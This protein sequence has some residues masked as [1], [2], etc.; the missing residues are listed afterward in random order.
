TYAAPG[1]AL[2]PSPRLDD[3]VPPVRRGHVDSRVLRDV[4]PAAR[5]QAARGRSRR[6]RAVST[7]PVRGAAAPVREGAALPLRVHELP[8]TAREGGVGEAEADRGVPP[9]GLGGRARALGASMTVR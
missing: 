3:V 5:G 2:P 1:R 6:A 4:V 8:R 9:A 7:G